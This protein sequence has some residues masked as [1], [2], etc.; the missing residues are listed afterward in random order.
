[1]IRRSCKK[2]KNKIIKGSVIR[3]KIG[4][5]NLRKIWLISPPIHWENNIGADQVLFKDSIVW[6]LDTFGVIKD[7]TSCDWIIRIHP[8]EKRL[9]IKNGTKEFILKKYKKIP[10][11]IKI[12][13]S[14]S[15]I[16]TYSFLPG[17]SGCIS[18]GST[19]GLETVLWQKP[20]FLVGLGYYGKR[21]F[22][23]QF[24]TKEEY[25]NTLKNIKNVQLPT[26][27]QVQMAERLMYNTWIYK[28]VP[29][30][31]S[32]DFKSLR[33]FKDHLKKDK[34]IQMF[35]RHMFYGGE[36]GLKPRKKTKKYPDWKLKLN[37]A[38]DA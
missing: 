3:K 25:F 6:I 4:L 26:T 27:K 7:L 30:N 36:F 20:T 17:I 16:S 18:I 22:T 1:M 13:S 32:L 15:T 28:Q 19:T 35:Y 29:F 12:I 31:L 5:T 24:E 11:H 37:R 9:K 23:N 14:G 10:Q 2:E 21:G 34:T 33:S 8:A 38:W